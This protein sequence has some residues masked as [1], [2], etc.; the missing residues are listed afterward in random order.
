MYIIK[1]ITNTKDIFTVS[2]A[3][4]ILKAQRI[5]RDLQLMSLT[6]WLEEVNNEI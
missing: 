2:P 4:E 5:L 1:F 6:A 3:M